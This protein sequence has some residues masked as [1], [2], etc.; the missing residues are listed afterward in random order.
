MAGLG[1]GLSMLFKIVGLYT[2]AAALLYAA[3]WA[4]RTGGRRP[5]R[6]IVE[7]GM[8]ALVAMV[9][10][11]V[12]SQMSVSAALVYVVP[13]TA[14]AAALALEARRAPP[15]WGPL[16]RAVLLVTVGAAVPVA[17]FA[18]HFAAHGAL[19]DLVRGTLVLPRVRFQSASQ[20]MPGV[21][22]LLV[23]IA[24]GLPLL[25][26]VRGGATLQRRVTVG[27]AL[28]LAGAF[29]ALGGGVVARYAVQA[30]RSWVVL[31]TVWGAWAV[32]RE[33]AGDRPGLFALLASAALWSLVQFPFAAEFYVF[34]VAPPALL[35]L[36]VLARSRVGPSGGPVML[37]Y[38]IA[39]LGY[40]VVNS[41]HTVGL[42]TERMAGMHASL[43]VP[44]EDARA[45]REL[46]DTL[47]NLGA[48][49]V[50]YATP[51]AAEV[52]FLAGAKS[53]TRT[54][55]DFLDEPEGRVGRIL[56]ALE[57]HQVRVVVL[58]GTGPFS[59]AVSGEL[60]RALETRYP[61]AIR[62]DRFEVRFLS[63]EGGE[64]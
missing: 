12:R 37:F 23:G 44:P 42:S 57:S 63:R 60:R 61:S 33:P 26:A 22:T 19:A 4:A 52:S 10:L 18:L 16:F 28:L 32:S 3:A 55:Y 7:S 41:R 34:Y 31:G 50:I 49:D 35:L 17:L 2:L 47:R 51:D 15:S 21:G 53:P 64:R 24:A 14:V 58:K 11:L 1:A 48:G 56:D 30:L 6:W 20:A 29:A 62:L 13:V 39:I 38:L 8:V 43:R 5:A 36:A 25:L 27:L 46:M 59:G 40:A 45:Y 54:L 9:V